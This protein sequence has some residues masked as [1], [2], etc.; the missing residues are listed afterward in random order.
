[1]LSSTKS[2]HNRSDL[3]RYALSQSIGSHVWMPT[4]MFQTGGA[5]WSVVRYCCPDPEAT[6]EI[7]RILKPSLIFQNPSDH[8]LY[9]LHVILPFSR[10]YF[11]ALLISVICLRFVLPLR[12]LAPAQTHTGRLLLLSLRHNN[13]VNQSIHH[14]FSCCCTC[15][16]PI[17]FP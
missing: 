13:T 2:L 1:M 16:F 7:F 5:W 12:P 10:P 9:L 8:N 3:L 17:L 11:S 14:P 4:G 15:L 6:S